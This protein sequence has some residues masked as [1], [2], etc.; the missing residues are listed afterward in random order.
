MGYGAQVGLAVGDDVWE[1]DMIRFKILIAGKRKN[2]GDA[3]AIVVFPNQES[4]ERLSILGF[5]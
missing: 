4:L 2:V 5:R 3:S 1:G